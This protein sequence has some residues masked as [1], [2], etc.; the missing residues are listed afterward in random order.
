VDLL[1]YG[2]A[3]LLVESA[4]RLLDG[5]GSGPNIQ[6]VLGDIPLYAGHV[7][8]TPREDIGVCAEKVDEHCFLFE[9]EPG[10]DPDLFGGVAAGVEG[11]GLNHPHWLQVAGMAFHVWHLLRE[12]F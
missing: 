12:A 1:A 7:R 8:G 4:Q 5:S 11:D 10:A 6:R 9:I 3:L 2:S